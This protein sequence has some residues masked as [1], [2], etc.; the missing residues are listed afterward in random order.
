VKVRKR[1]F[2]TGRGDRSRILAKGKRL[3]PE[4]VNGVECHM[5]RN[6]L[7]NVP[8]SLR[9]LTSFLV[10]CFNPGICDNPSILNNGNRILVFRF[11]DNI[12]NRSG[13]VMSADSPEMGLNPCCVP[14]LR[15]SNAPGLARKPETDERATIHLMGSNSSPRQSWIKTELIENTFSVKMKA[16]QRVDESTWT[17]VWPR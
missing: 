6:N 17:M 3:L 4:T 9:H 10:T 16:S 15:K 13:I 7:L 12:F 8:D 11:D 1:L 14:K 5:L 2:Q